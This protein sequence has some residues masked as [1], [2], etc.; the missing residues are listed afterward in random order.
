MGEMRAP[1][2]QTG[3]R[4]AAPAMVT[5]ATFVEVEPC[6]HEDGRAI[7]EGFRHQL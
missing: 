2:P 1:Y 5:G 7:G 4:H 3:E 6:R